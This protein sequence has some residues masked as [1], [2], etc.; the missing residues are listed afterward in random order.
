MW[1][2]AT[3]N[4]SNWNKIYLFPK[5]QGP[6]IEIN[7]IQNF[8]AKQKHSCETRLTFTIFEFSSKFSALIESLG[9][10]TFSIGEFPS[11]V[12]VNAREYEESPD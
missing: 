12:A 11:I 5:T 9:D 6:H 8:F 2:N 4:K 10:V 1:Q 3:V 7:M